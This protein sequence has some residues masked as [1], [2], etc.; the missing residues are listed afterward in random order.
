MGRDAYGAFVAGVLFPIQER[1]KGHDTGRR[2]RDLE[3]SQWWDGAA[4]ATFQ[5]ERLRRFLDAIGREVPRYR[6]LYRR[7]GFQPTSIRGVADLAQLPLL[8]KADIRAEKS[9]FVR[10]GATR[11]ATNS[12]GGSTGEPLQF[13]VGPDRVTSDVA[14]R[15]RAMRW[16]DVDLGDPEV[17]LWGS[18]IELTRQDTF[19][20]LRDTLFRSTF[21]SAVGLEPARMDGYLDA[22][23]RARPRQIFS[24]A[25]AL[26]EVAGHAERRGR[27][28]RD[29][30]IRVIF[31]TSEE[32]YP[33]QR[34]QLERVFGCPVANNYGARDAGFVAHD[35]PRGGMH[36]S[37]EDIVLEILDE[38][39]APLPP[40]SA[41]EI[42]VTHLE[43]RDFPFV[44]YRTGDI[45]VLD[46][47][48]CG[49]GRGLP[50]LKGLQG[51]ADDLLLTLDGARIPGQMVVHLVRSRPEVQ[52]FKI[53]QET[54]E[55]IRILLVAT[56]DPTAEAKGEIT[57]GVQLL[58][59]AATR[60]EF[61]RV[62]AIPREASGKYRT[63][64]SRLGRSPMLEASG[65]GPAAR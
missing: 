35:C 43:S 14:H 15:R 6:D 2:L 38:R 1:L 34:E 37:A 51:R 16:W 53:V 60:V 25:S 24:H 49:C 48:P 54:Q 36:V 8:T 55:V 64:V 12:T 4:L 32:L 5:M 28:L 33:F 47:A 30:G 23:V 41:G 42:V 59:G 45:G 20:S 40:G 50:L 11:L 46:D 31:V 26:C 13:F 56:E 27:S 3:R 10:E 57:R 63:V 7:I 9:A 17:V 58:L 44:R 62:T 65:G 19:R 52:A 61:E 29:L 22:I 39:G 21:L 18:P